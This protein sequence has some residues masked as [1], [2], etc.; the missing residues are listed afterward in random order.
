MNK[1]ILLIDDEPDILKTLEKA[2]D[3]EGYQ[4]VC[5]GGGEAALEIFRQQTFDLVITDMRM[6]GMSG[7]QLIAQ[8]KSLDPDVEAIVLTGYG[9]LDNAVHALQGLGA[10]DYLTKP[11]ENIDDLFMTVEK[12]LEKRR[13]S[14][15]NREL[16]KSLKEKEAEL[17][18]QNQI[19]QE[20]EK[21]Y[22]ELADSVPVSL[23]ETDKNGILTFLNPY[24]LEIFGYSQQNLARKL[25]IQDM[26]ASECWEM[27]QEH[28]RNRIVHT[29]SET[30]ESVAMRKDETTF[31]VLVKIDPILNG[32]RLSGFRGFAL[33]ITDREQ[34]LDERMRMAKLQSLG[35]LAGGIAHDFNNILSVILGNIELAQFDVAPESRAHHALANAAMGCQTATELTGRFIT[36]SEGGAPEK[37]TVSMSALLNN[38]VPLFFSGTNVK[39]DFSIPPDL[40]AAHVDE[41][42]LG[43]AIHNVILN[44]IDA[45][46]HGGIVRVAAENLKIGDKRQLNGT[47]IPPGLYL[48]LKIQD[49]GVGIAQGHLSHVLDPYFSTKDRGIQKGMG[50]GL[51]TS[52]SIIRK[53]GGFL[54]LESEVSVGTTVSIYL[55]AVFQDEQEP[56]VDAIPPVRTDSTT[57]T[58]LKVLVMDDEKP[59]RIMAEKMLQRLGCRVET[60]RDATDAVMHYKRALAASEPFDLVLLDLTVKGGPGG[61]EVI[62]ELLMLNPDV[63][64]VVCSGYAEDPVMWNYQKYGFHAALPKPF[65]KKSLEDAMRKAL[66]QAPLP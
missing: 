36:F 61:K 26:L 28:V 7:I 13:L 3:L 58:A 50:L 34:R 48:K 49:H 55:P 66:G 14:L 5:A 10:F 35:T 42:Q 38:M 1:N 4:V 17:L 21:K 64:A 46:P 18:K 51:S 32:K 24:A 2:L 19:L 6:P 54:I 22:R 25:R 60:A 15:E 52:F 23:F 20:N 57:I 37:R 59:L 31:P 56:E 8:V 9:T 41:A 33:D 62:Q 16:L 53:H 12:A 44:A 63:I 45:M 65:M 39:C 29:S 47:I 40:W 43:Q 11:L 27:A 30:I